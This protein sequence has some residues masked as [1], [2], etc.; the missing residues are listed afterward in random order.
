MMSA[1]A[2]TSSGCPAGMSLYN[3]RCYPSGD[4]GG[5]MMMR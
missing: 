2:G 1:T 5:A 3:E 4:A